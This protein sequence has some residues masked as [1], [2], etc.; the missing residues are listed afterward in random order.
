MKLTIYHWIT[1][2]CL[3]ASFIILCVIA[4][5]SSRE[6]F[7]PFM[8]KACTENDCNTDEGKKKAVEACTKDFTTSSGYDMMKSACENPDPDIRMYGCIETCDPT[9]LSAYVRYVPPVQ[10]EQAPIVAVS[11]PTPDEPG[12]KGVSTGQ[13]A[14]TSSP[15][16]L[17]TNPT[18]ADT[19]SSA[20]SSMMTASPSVATLPSDSTT[21]PASTAP[22]TSG[23]ASTPTL[24]AWIQ[25]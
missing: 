24:P 1:L 20:P 17:L 5:S 19:S 6:R 4:V 15:S 14:I 23:S 9:Q 18:V 8:D 7:G 3:L 10:S 12:I 16:S 22:S 25:Y 13:V 21:A 2:F 11:G